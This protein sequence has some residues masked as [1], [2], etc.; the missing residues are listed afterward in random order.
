MMKRYLRWIP[1]TLSLLLIFGLIFQNG[2]VSK[3]LIENAQ[4]VIESVVHNQRSGHW[5][6]DYLLMKNLGHILEYLL[7]GLS[8]M[9]SSENSGKWNCS[10]WRLVL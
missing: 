3:Q 5:C 8:A 1:L 6:N 10:A 2:A 9:F 4:F 7:L